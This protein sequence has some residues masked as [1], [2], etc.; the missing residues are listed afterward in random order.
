VRTSIVPRR[1]LVVAGLSLTFAVFLWATPSDSTA[2]NR[3][4]GSSDDKPRS[5]V[6]LF[7]RIVEDSRQG[8]GY[9]EAAGE[10][11]RAGE[12]PTRSVFNWRQPFMY[13]ALSHAPTLF[14][15][16][17]L[18]VLAAKLL[19]DTGK[20]LRRETFALVPMGNSCIGLLVP[21]AVYLTEAWAGALIALSLL[22]YARNRERAGAV[23][24]LAA[25]FVRELAG[26][27][28]LFATGVALWHR[29]WHEVRIW[30]AGGALYA[31]YY[32]LHA[33]HVFQHIRPD[34]RSQPN[35]WVAFG[36]LPFLAETWKTNGLLLQAPRVVVAIVAVALV[37]AWWN[38][39]LPL[40]ARVTLIMYSAMFLV[41]GQPFNGYW[42]LLIAPTASLW[43]AYSWGGL[44]TLWDPAPL[45][46]KP[47][48]ARASLALP[49]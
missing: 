33:L 9:Y 29:R 32:G 42:G 34:D 4:S 21:I 27:Y 18:A 17:C 20:T 19:S 12:Y 44:R 22:S 45:A 13:L 16:L 48:P 41:I 10:E 7:I 6:Q 11:M 38:R 36:G 47:L 26:P 30:A 46:S 39:C 1:A 37:A 8:K 15:Q 31:S 2:V 24:G 35:S 3:G 40:H 5:D 43:L 28:C 25:V 49:A 14:A 23:W